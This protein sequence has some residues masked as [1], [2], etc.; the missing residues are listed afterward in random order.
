MEGYPA[1]A[2]IM[3]NHDELAIFRRFKELNILNLLYSQAEI[4]DLEAD[5]AILRAVDGA[6]PERAAYNRHWWSLAKSEKDADKEQWRK[7]E[8]IRQ[9]LEAYSGL[10]L[11]QILLGK[12]MRRSLLSEHRSHILLGTCTLQNKLLLLFALFYRADALVNTTYLSLQQ[13]I[14]LRS[15][16]S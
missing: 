14:V 9:K 5:L 12:A 11:S 1:V 4:I 6:Q 3:S 13:I 15:R 16:Y 8:E 7:I 10:L 2:Q